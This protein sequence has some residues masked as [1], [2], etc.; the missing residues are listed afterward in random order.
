MNFTEVIREHKQ[1]HSRSQVVP[2]TAESI[3]QTGQSAHS[4]SYS[5]VHS[6]HVASANQVAI[7]VA[8]PRLIDYGLELSWRV[9]CY[10]LRGCID[11]NQLRIVNASAETQTNSM[12]ISIHAVGRELK[13]AACSLIQLFNKYFRILSC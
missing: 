2:F 11:F 7:R 3:R 9:A 10:F 4:H 1:S 6:F 13:L 12:R 5:Q 8:D